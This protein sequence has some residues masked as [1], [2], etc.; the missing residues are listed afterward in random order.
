MENA[1]PLRTSE[2][3]ITQP[4]TEE[5]RVCINA[6]QLW[7]GDARMPGWFGAKMLMDLPA[8][9]LPLTLVADVK[10]EPTD[11]VYR[12]WGS[13]FSKMHGYDLTG[14]SCQL[15]N[16]DNLADIVFQSQID[17]CQRKAPLLYAGETVSK[18]EVVMNEI[19]WRAPLSSDGET[20]DK[21]ISICWMNVSIAQDWFSHT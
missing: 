20:V 21:I 9:V 12:Y 11:F 14:K 3:D 10:A 2:I 8:P 5:I 16:P 17:V 4:P 18:G 1:Y 19:V 7:C 6:W 13:G 15:L